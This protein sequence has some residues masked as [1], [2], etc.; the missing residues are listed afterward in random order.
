[1]ILPAFFIFIYCC[2]HLLVS[3]KYNELKIS[4]EYQSDIQTDTQ[5]FFLRESQASLKYSSNNELK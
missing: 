1:M 3:I 5:N 4:F 2:Q